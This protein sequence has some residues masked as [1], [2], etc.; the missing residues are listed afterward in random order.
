M[1]SVT[2]YLRAGLIATLGT[3]MV[4]ATSVS[5]QAQNRGEDLLNFDHVRVAMDYFEDPT[6]RHLAD[7]AFTEAA[8]HL[9]RHAGITAFYPAGASAFDISA[10]LLREIPS[11]DF[12][13][14]I[15]ERVTRVKSDIPAQEMC[16]NEAREYLP[17][18]TRFQAPLYVTWGYDLGASMDG[19]SSINI[20]HPKF[21]EDLGEFWFYCIHQMHHA[22]LTA[23]NPWPFAMREISTT[24]E[25][26]AQIEY[27]TFLE[28]TAVY[29]AYDARKRASALQNDEDYIA[30]DDPLRMD[31]YEAR[32]ADILR[33]FRTHDRALDEDDWALFD[34]LT[35]GERLLYR[36]GAK[37]AMTIDRVLGRPALWD[38][39]ASGP[40]RFFDL[41]EAAEIQTRQ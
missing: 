24:L 19:T 1:K 22:G 27:L 34:E 37:M 13:V 7:V 21:G 40:G 33:R 28:G 2:S 5:V 12:I 26:Q 14:E 41:Y 8:E 9:R 35:N 39:A 23:L 31:R 6:Q 11:T 30:L 38:A 25:M 18:N 36:V 10:D 17:D 32:F 16:F 20:T 15:A 29:A 3:V 4:Q